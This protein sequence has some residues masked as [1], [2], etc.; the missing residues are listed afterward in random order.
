[1]HPG[2]TLNARLKAGTQLLTDIVADSSDEFSDDD[3]IVADTVVDTATADTVVDTAAAD[4]V[5]EDF[6]DDGGEEGG[7]EE[8]QNAKDTDISNSIGDNGAPSPSAAAFRSRDIASKWEWNQQTFSS[9]FLSRVAIDA[10]KPV[11]H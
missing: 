11:G 2:L 4:T 1:M 9:E 5:V 6:G 3:D 8:C 7:E 10:N